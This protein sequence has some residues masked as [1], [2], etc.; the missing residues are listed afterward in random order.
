VGTGYINPRS[1]FVNRECRCTSPNIE[2]AAEIVGHVI[3]IP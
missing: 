3:R 1:E 2:I